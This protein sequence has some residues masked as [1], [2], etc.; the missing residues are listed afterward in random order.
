MI[1]SLTSIATIKLSI[2]EPVPEKD[3][4]AF[5]KEIREATI[6]DFIKSLENVLKENG[7]SKTEISIELIEGNIIIEEETKEGEIVI[8]EC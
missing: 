8:E 3:A 5:D 4:K 6:E 1:K 7:T 2:K